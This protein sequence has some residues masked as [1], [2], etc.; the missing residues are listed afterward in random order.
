M[1]RLRVVNLDSDGLNQNPCTSQGDN[2]GTRWHGEVNEEMV[3]GWHASA[4]LC[5]L[6]VDCSMEGHVTSYF[7]QRVDGQS[8][9]PEVGDGSTDH[10]D[11]HDDTLVLEFLYTSMVLGMVNAKEK[12]CVLQRTK[13]YWLEGT[14]ILQVWED[15][16]VR[17]V[18]HSTQRRCIMRH[19]HEELGHFGVKQTYS[20]F[21]GQYWWRGIHTNV[22]QLVS[23]YMV[24]D[25]VK[26][27]FNAPTP[28]LHP[29]LIMGWVIAGVW[30]LQ[31]HYHC[32]Y[33]IIDMCW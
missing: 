9:N 12:D 16:R 19:A 1:H 5:L 22:Q 10:H 21:L 28:H 27:S 4:F 11:V 6:G 30:T 32:W 3:L 13:R 14:H 7:S 25:R 20:L 2:T 33:D 26:A 18:P 17:I 23:H 31:D 15:G 8:S 24:C 29:L